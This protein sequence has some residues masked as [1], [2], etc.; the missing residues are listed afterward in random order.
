MQIYLFICKLQTK[1]EQKKPVRAVM[2][3]Q[4]LLLHYRP[5]DY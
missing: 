3:P 1:N 2:V 4:T 5:A